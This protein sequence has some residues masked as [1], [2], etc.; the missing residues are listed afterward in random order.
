MAVLSALKTT[1]LMS[2]QK[3]EVYCLH[4]CGKAYRVKLGHLDQFVSLHR[5]E[6]TS[7]DLVIYGI[8]FD[9]SSSYSHP[10]EWYRIA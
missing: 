4:L 2:N 9:F 3:F 7:D 8:D 5:D 6:L 10:Y 1:C